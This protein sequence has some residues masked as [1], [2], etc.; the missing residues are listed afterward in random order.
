[1]KVHGDKTIR[2]RDG[3][4]ELGRYESAK[5]ILKEDFGNMCGYCGKNS[6]VMNERFHIDH[7][8][9]ISL[10]PEKENDYYNLV[11]AC[12]KCNLTK[13]NKWP[14]NNKNLANDGEIGFVDPATE[15]YDNHIVR[16]D[17][18]FIKG[19]TSLGRNM[20]KSLNFDVRRTDLYWKIQ[21]LY[22]IQTR[23]EQLS[24]EKQLDEEEL[25]YYMESN[26]FLKRYIKEAFEK[27]E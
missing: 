16:D 3:I 6:D 25:L 9:P 1:M 8:V 23:L 17:Q 21:G 18:G 11:L 10:A 7:F 20:C 12:P 4:E 24:D 14:T 5:S 15:E 13:S 27:G 26:K 2:R 19:I 22:Q